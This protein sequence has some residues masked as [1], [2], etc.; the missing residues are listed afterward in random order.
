MHYLYIDID[1]YIHIPGF[2]KTLLSFNAKRYIA[3]TQLYNFFYNFAGTIN[4]KE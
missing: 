1:I 3:K 4:F 2:L